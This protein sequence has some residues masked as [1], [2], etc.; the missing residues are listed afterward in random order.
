MLFRSE[1]KWVI[2]PEHMHDGKEIAA[3]TINFGNFIQ[4]TVDFLIIAFSIFI[5]IKLITNFMQKKEAP[6]PPPAPPAPSQEEILLTEIR[7]ILK[8]QNSK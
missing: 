2:R 3:I 8:Q 1:L 5:F 7:D 4:A 6:A